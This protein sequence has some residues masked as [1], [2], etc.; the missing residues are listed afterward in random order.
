M[1]TYEIIFRVT[2]TDDVTPKDI[3]QDIIWSNSD[4][5]DIVENS[6]KVTEVENV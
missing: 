3:E 6:I 4:I 1:K 2:D 5:F